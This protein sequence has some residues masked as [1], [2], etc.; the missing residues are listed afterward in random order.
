MMNRMTKNKVANYF[1]NRGAKAHFNYMKIE[2][3]ELSAQ[4]GKTELIVSYQLYVLFE[5]LAI[6]SHYFQLRGNSLNLLISNRI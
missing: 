3:P 2:D 5:W 1:Q 4:T 6:A